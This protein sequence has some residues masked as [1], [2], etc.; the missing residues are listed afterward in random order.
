[1]SW[2]LFSLVLASAT[3]WAVL[4]L[5][6][7]P[8][9]ELRLHGR[10]PLKAVGAWAVVAA[11][12]P[13]LVFHWYLIFAVISFVAWTKL[14]R[15]AGKFWLA[16]AGSLGLSLGIIFPL[17]V[18]TVLLA[19]ESPLALASLYLG[20][21]TTALAYVACVRSR[22]GSAGIRSSGSAKWLAICSLAWTV[23]LSYGMLHE[24]RFPRPL[25]LPGGNPQTIL[26]ANVWTPL[27]PALFVVALAFAA[28]TAARRDA[29]SKARWLAGAAAVAAL[30]TSLLAQF[31]IRTI[32]MSIATG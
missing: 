4:M 20:G 25:N 28:W 13:Q 24:A 3:G 10:E 32:D 12:A 22:L 29:L 23:L 14:D 9:T 27:I 15:L 19:L 17:E 1:M 6:Y 16:V 5:G 30:I 2:N 26:T 7:L 21:A 8:V 11:T 18:S 31:V